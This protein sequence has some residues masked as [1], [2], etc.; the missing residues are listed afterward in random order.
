MKWNHNEK[1]SDGQVSGRLHVMGDIMAGYEEGRLKW[2]SRWRYFGKWVWRR[3]LTGRKT[4]NY[5]KGEEHKAD[6]AC[7]HVFSTRTC[8]E[9]RIHSHGK[10]CMAELLAIVES[11]DL[12]WDL[13][14]CKILTVLI[15][16]LCY[17]NYIELD[18]RAIPIPVFNSS[19]EFINS[20]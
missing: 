12:V 18:N 1:I 5:L 13:R 7:I 2:T 16:Q 19:Y 8:V 9:V 6:E 3:P 11:V 4:V 20:L 15:I 10:W 17:G 14:V